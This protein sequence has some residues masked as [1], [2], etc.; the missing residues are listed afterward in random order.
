MGK[1][2][3]YSQKDRDL[4]LSIFKN[5]RDIRGNLFKSKKISPKI[6]KKLL[7]SASL[8]PSVGYSQPWE[9]VVIKDKKIKNRVFKNFQRENQ[10]AKKKFKKTIYSKLKLEGIKEAPINIAILYKKPKKATLGQTS[11][12]IVG[13]YS[14]VCAIQNLWLMARA[15]NIGVG[16]VSI[17]DKN[18]FKKIIKIK[19]KLIAYLCL[20]YSREFY[21]KPEL[22]RK[23]WAKKKR[24][25]IKYL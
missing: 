8:A 16:W 17:L 14:V 22:K 10:K 21:K 15:Y 18:R 23:K 6:I 9:F 1:I 7:K 19:H 3:K 4:L 11:Q 20:G 12:K 5:R 2:I 13:E 25:E 24:L